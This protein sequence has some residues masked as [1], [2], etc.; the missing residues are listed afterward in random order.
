MVQYSVA[1]RDA[2]NDAIETTIGTTPILQIRSGLPPANAAAADAGTV[3]ATMNLPSDWM[4]ASSAGVK[5][6]LGTWQD[7]SAD[8]AGLA[9][10]FRIK[11][12]AGSAT[13]IQGL[14]SEPWAGSK[15]YLLNQQAHNGGNV[16]RVTTAGT[17][18]SSGGPTGTGTGI[19]DGS[20]TWAY[21]GPLDMALDNTNLNAG[22]QVT[23]STFSITRGNA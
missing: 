8:A 1:V 13:H 6:L 15:A 21:V 17:S 10:H 2:Q 20:V 11:D 12:S 5:S 9:G 16:Y 19:T 7:A 22:Q 14:C 4:S 3:L 23:V 18:A